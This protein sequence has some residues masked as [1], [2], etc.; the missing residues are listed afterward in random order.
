MSLDYF[1]PL[2]S[3]QPA[4]IEL[5]AATRAGCEPP[6][7]AGESPGTMAHACMAWPSMSHLN[8][9]VPVNVLRP[10]IPVVRAVARTTSSTLGGPIP[11]PNNPHPI[12][13]RP[14]DE[15]LRQHPPC[16]PPDQA[17]RTLVRGIRLVCSQ[18]RGRDCRVKVKKGSGIQSFPLGCGPPRTHK[19]GPVCA[20][21]LH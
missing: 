9:P 5:L 20:L 18:G 19:L 8:F 3:A 6:E 12:P 14:P 11:F 2:I 15:S 21:V 13:P 16:L 17:A 10:Y 1:P 4:S 7:T